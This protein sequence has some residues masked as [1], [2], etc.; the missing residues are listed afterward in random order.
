MTESSNYDEAPPVPP[1]YGIWRR[2]GTREFE[3]KYLFYST[4]PPGKFD[5]I[6]SGGGWG[7]AGFGQLV[8][9]ITVAPDGQSF[10]STIRYDAFDAAGKPVEGGGPANGNATRIG[11]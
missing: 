11:W 4:R 10:T 6:A 5:E 9:Q 3:A 7:P 8:E 1:A 2:V